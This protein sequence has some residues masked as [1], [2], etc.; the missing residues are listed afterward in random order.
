MAVKKRKF[1]LNDTDIQIVDVDELC[2]K[3]L[4][5]GE[6]EGSLVLREFA[7]KEGIPIGTFLDWVER[8]E[9]L[10]SAYSIARSL[11]GCRR[12]RGALEGLYSVP[13]VLR[14]QPIYDAEFKNMMEWE[15]KLK[16]TEASSQSQK[17]VVLERFP[18]SDVVP[19]CES[20]ATKESKKGESHG[21][22]GREDLS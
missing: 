14:F 10:K 19:E 16:N 3:I 11:V 8:N 2:Q 12:E 13:M 15:S 17:I 9:K 6:K 18:E 1:Y 4:A 20:L 22:K 7:A 5:W 21:T